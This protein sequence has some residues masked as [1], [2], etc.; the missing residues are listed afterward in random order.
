MAIEEVQHSHTMDLPP[1]IQIDNHFKLH[2][3][4]DLLFPSLGIHAKYLQ[5]MMIS[6]D[7]VLLTFITPMP[8]ITKVL[9]SIIRA[10]RMFDNQ[11]CSKANRD[12][13]IP[14]PEICSHIDN[15]MKG[16]R[17][18]IQT[19]VG[20]TLLRLKH[21]TRYVPE[22][23]N[24]FDR[25]LR[26]RKKRVIAAT[27]VGVDAANKRAVLAEDIEYVKENH[28][29]LKKFTL[30]LSD[31]VKM[32]A[33]VTDTKFND[34]A[35][36]I[37]DLKV[38]LVHLANDMKANIRSVLISLNGLMI[39]AVSTQRW[40]VAEMS[41]MTQG[42]SINRIIAKIALY[43]DHLVDTLTSS[44][45]KLELGRV[46]SELIT[47]SE[48]EEILQTA[49]NQ[50]YQIHPQYEFVSMT[51]PP[52][53]EISNAI[54]KVEEYQ[55]YI[56]IPVLLREKT[57]SYMDVYHL[58]NFHVPTDVFRA[59]QPKADSSALSYTKIE[60]PYRT[61]GI[62]RR[63]YVLLHEN[64]LQDCII[65]NEIKVCSAVLMQTHKT[66]SSCVASL[67]WD[68]K[69]EN[70]N[71]YCNVKYYHN[72]H[73]PAQVFST[74][75]V[76]LLANIHSEWE[77]LCNTDSIP[78]KQT[79]KRYA[80]I[81]KNHLCN[82]KVIIGNDH[83]L[84]Q[85]LSGCD[86]EKAELKIAYATNAIVLFNIHKLT[87]K[88]KNS[89]HYFDLHYQELNHSIPEL[90]VIQTINRTNILYD[91]PR[92]GVEF[93]K[94]IDAINRDQDVYMES[95]DLLATE[96]KLTFQS[97]FQHRHFP[98]GIS[99]IFSMIGIICLI[100]FI[101]YCYRQHKANT[102]GKAMHAVATNALPMPGINI[103]V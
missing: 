87:D 81:M 57:Q 74:H 44:F 17:D 25:R 56:Q 67:F 23:Y 90:K 66:V 92:T 40:S 39:K 30:R 62:S 5:S 97:F 77:I 42:F 48:F 16:F 20:E 18:A 24:L 13:D 94:V 98:L 41:L 3:G 86:Q 70:I 93:N 27:I 100:I 31:D 12:A 83:Y 61:V 72:M 32:L 19:L 73:V 103:S 99:F 71:K 53:Y 101:L 47:H 7:E 6:Q 35:D 29:V 28:K 69:I 52:Y 85:K 50:L 26:P 15:M 84:A 68:S 21:L 4:K 11:T 59:N 65:F 75:D 10:E 63:S 2:Q 22:L 51:A 102:L 54:Y 78:R 8:N 37:Q 45:H 82:C 60:L 46:P 43:L 55:L 96:R 1:P 79:G 76:L 9:W 95:E 49:S 33:K 91:R 36:D 64:Q 38:E 89:S 58:V 34:T 88:I 80:V 14:G